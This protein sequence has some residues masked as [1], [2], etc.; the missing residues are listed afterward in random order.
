MSFLVLIPFLLSVSGILVIQS[1]C[2]CSG[3]NNISIY[4]PP[5]TCSSIMDD[6]QH[7]FDF[8]AANLGH[9]CE[10]EALHDECGLE[11]ICH[12]CGCES[13]EAQFFKLKNQFTEKKVSD[14][15]SLV[16][17]VMAEILLYNH[18]SDRGIVPENNLNWFKYPPPLI[19]SQSTFIHFI[20]KTKIPDI[21]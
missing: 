13:P 12:S 8:H 19:A 9:C 4:L 21:A 20:C 17:K 15:K 14:V 11:D 1:H 6:H 10:H 18:V 7:L 2:S 5:E 3:K 16:S